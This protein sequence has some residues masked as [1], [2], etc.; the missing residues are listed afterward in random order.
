MVRVF[1]V[2]DV[3]ERISDIEQEAVFSFPDAEID[4]LGAQTVPD[5]VKLFQERKGAF[6]LV[7]LDLKLPQDDEGGLRLLEQFASEA[8]NTMYVLSS[9]SLVE[10]EPLRIGFPPGFP[11][12]NFRLVPK[13]AGRR[14]LLSML[15]GL[16]AREASTKSRGRS[17]QRR[18]AGHR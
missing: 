9:G 2:D 10:G 5:A 1:V 3:A 12:E 7:V 4:V 16:V 14:T 6:D 13:S 18:A 8:P 11:P 17:S 15:Q